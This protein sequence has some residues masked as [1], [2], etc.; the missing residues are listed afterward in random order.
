MWNVIQTKFPEFQLG[1]CFDFNAFVTPSTFNVSLHYLNDHFFGRDQYLK[2]DD[3]KPIMLLWP[4]SNSDTTL[5]SPDGLHAALTASGLGLEDSLYVFSEWGNPA[6]L[7]NAQNVNIYANLGVFNWVFPFSKSSWNQTLQIQQVIADHAN[8]IALSGTSWYNSPFGI[9][10]MYSGFSDHY[11]DD[12]VNT[13]DPYNQYNLLNAD[14]EYLRLLYDYFEDW[15]Y[16]PFL[17][18]IPTWNDYTEGT[19]IEPHVPSTGCVYGCTFS[20]QNPYWSLVQI[21]KNFVNADVDDE[22]LQSEFEAVTN[23]FFPNFHPTPSPT[24]S[25]VTQSPTVYPV[26]EPTIS[27]SSVPTTTESTFSPTLDPSSSSTNSWTSGEPTALPTTDPISDLE[28]AEVEI[29]D[30]SVDG[31][32]DNHNRLL[33]ILVVVGIVTVFVVVIVGY[34]WW[35]KSLRIAK[36]NDILRQSQETM[37]GQEQMIELEESMDTEP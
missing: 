9:D 23:R 8:F 13:T 2:Y 20:A 17:I 14:Y 35:M 6:F 33:W 12:T 15:D 18:Q 11:I 7:Y 31:E 19:M 24:G 37:D 26:T 28:D 1:I 27:P 29:V 30:E 5:Q 3:G 25:P 32:G 21:H 4:S 34:L 22:W 36:D 10:S 16:E